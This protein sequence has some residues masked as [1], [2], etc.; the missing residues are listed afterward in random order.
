MHCAGAMRYE[1]SDGNVVVEVA[2][3]LLPAQGLLTTA[4]ARRSR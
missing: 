2:D 3:W 1:A 4:P